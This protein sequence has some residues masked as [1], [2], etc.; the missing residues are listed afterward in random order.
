M[1]INIP[2]EQDIFRDKAIQNV[3]NAFVYITD[4]NPPLKIY[5][6]RFG[7]KFFSGMRDIRNLCLGIRYMKYL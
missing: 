5:D 7:N 1:E 2:T 6:A 4:C 3:N